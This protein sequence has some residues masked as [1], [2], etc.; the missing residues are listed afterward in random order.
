M[1]RLISSLLFCILPFGALAEPELKGSPDV[2]RQFLHPSENIV[3]LSAEA[4]EKAY[5]DR[6]II[7]LVVTS[8]DEQLSASISKNILR[9]ID[10]SKKRRAL[11]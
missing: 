6:A 3:T 7:S 5:S 2:L 9:A 11:L 1:S 4:E 10:G 8:L